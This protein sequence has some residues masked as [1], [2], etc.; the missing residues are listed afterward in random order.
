MK[1]LRM[2]RLLVI[3]L[4][5]GLWH[6][7]HAQDFI[8]IFGS[9]FY[10]ELDDATMTAKITDNAHEIDDAE[11]PMVFRTR[12]LKKIK[13]NLLEIPSTVN[14]KGKTYTVTGIGRAAFADYKNFK[15]VKIPETVVT[16]EEYAFFRTQLVE[17]KIPS[18]VLYIGDRAFGWCKHLRRIHLPQNVA[19]GI[20]VYSEAPKDIRII[21]FSSVNVAQKQDV[22]SNKIPVVKAITKSDID[23]DIPTVFSN[24]NKTFAIIIANENYQDDVA[25]DY[26]LQ[27]GRTF[28]TYC[29]QTLGLPKENIRF[30]ENATLNNIRSMV[31]WISNVAK[32]YKGEAKILFYY[33]GHGVPDEN[34]STSL[35]PVDGSAKDYM[36][37]YSLKLLYSKLGSLAAKNVCV[38]LDA[39][40]SG[41]QRNDDMLVAARGIRK[42]KEEKPLGNMIVFSASKEDE[43]AHSYPEKGHGLF[44]YYLIKKIKETK[45]NVTLGELAD[46]IEEKVTQRSIVILNTMQTPTTST[47]TMMQSTWREMKLK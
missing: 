13:G 19:M 24:A 38:F 12:K 10:V 3:V 27:D 26:A 9:E 1:P 33:A 44:T 45:G 11:F 35:L 8:D 30:Q 17:A 41:K 40:F 46:Y 36:T 28:Y 20:D 23:E 22:L 29:N 32:A 42:A 39:C 34:G 18:S 15:Y 31:N 14:I 2:L 4:L 37:G 7:A 16:I 25:V 5:I 43:T 6:T 21:N 47:S